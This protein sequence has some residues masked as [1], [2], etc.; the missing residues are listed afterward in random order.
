[1]RKYFDSL[2]IFRYFGI[3]RVANYCSTEQAIFLWQFKRRQLS[4]LQW[5]KRVASFGNECDS[6]FAV[7][8]IHCKSFGIVAAQRSYSR[9][10]I[11]SKNIYPF[12]FGI[13]LIA[14][15][16]LV[17]FVKLD[18]LIWN[19]AYY[20]NHRQLFYFFG[21]QWPLSESNWCYQ[22]LSRYDCRTAVN[23]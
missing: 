2:V 3:F 17:L 6:K 13:S 9:N 16:L 14:F 21:W 1:M 4:F 10:L 18:T 7:S 8:Y 12:A 23:L 5:T 15:V 20:T 11:L 22:H 19:W